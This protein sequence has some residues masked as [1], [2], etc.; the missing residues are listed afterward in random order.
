MVEIEEKSMKLCFDCTWNDEWEGIWWLYNCN[1]VKMLP[2]EYNFSL[3]T[4][5]KQLWT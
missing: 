2:W 3:K 1:L 5:K 4:H